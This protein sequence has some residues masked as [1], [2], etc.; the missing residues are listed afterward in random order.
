[1]TWSS[2]GLHSVGF[3]SP[4]LWVVVETRRECSV[5]LPSHEWESPLSSVLK[6]NI[7]VQWDQ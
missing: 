7:F 1:M 6:F 3:M 5:E 2:E 4:D